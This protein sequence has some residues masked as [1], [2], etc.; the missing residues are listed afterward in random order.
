M[1]RIDSILDIAKSYLGVAE[2]S[3]KH[4]EIISYYNKARYADAYKM[5]VNDPWCAAFV[6]A[7]FAR[8]NCADLIPCV[9]S[10]DQMISYFKKWNRFH[11]MSEGTIVRGDILFYDW[12]SDGG[13]DHVGIVSNNNM[14]TLQ[15]IEGNKTDSVGYRNIRIGDPTIV[16]VG[17]PAYDADSGVDSTIKPIAQYS[18][19]FEQFSYSDRKTIFSLPILQKGSVGVYVR[20]LQVLLKFKNGFNIEIDG[21]FGEETDNAVLNWQLI[22]NLEIDGVVGRETWSSL[23]I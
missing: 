12:N 2:G 1:S 13:S 16:G 23:L 9:A 11:K 8:A 6:V 4:S 7:C 18:T 22:K 5:T 15:V 19:Y 3:A 14:G 17:R 21:D 20:I 10:C